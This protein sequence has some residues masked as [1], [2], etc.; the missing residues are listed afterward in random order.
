MPTILVHCYIDE[1]PDAAL[2]DI[3]DEGI[4]RILEWIAKA[5]ELR[6]SGIRALICEMPCAIRFVSS[7]AEGVE[8]HTEGPFSGGYPV[9]LPNVVC[10]LSG[11]ADLEGE[12]TEWETLRIEGRAISFETSIKYGNL[13]TTADIPEEFLR[14][15]QTG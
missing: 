8:A 2:I 14:G 12:R 3:D 13:A 15:M 1:G 9:L 6:S 5:Q 7:S 10:E 4:R 11:I